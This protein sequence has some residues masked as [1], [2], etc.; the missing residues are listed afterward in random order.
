MMILVAILFIATAL[1]VVSVV[2]IMIVFVS[3]VVLI[4]VFDWLGLP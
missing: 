3:F 2:G 4:K 1:S